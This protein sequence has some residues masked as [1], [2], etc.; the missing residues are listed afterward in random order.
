METEGRLSWFPWIDYRE[1]KT[2]RSRVL[3]PISQIRKK[4]AY[5]QAWRSDSQVA[6]L[7]STSQYAIRTIC[8]KIDLS[9][10]FHAIEYGAGTGE[11]AR[12]LL[13]RM[14]PDS[15]L[16]LIEKNPH[17]FEYLK[18]IT[19]PRVTAYLDS[20]ENL[21]EI[22]R[23]M[24]IKEIDYVISGIPFS[25]FSLETKREIL[26]NSHQ[27]LK[28]GSKFVAYQSLNHIQKHLELYFRRVTVQFEWRNIPP[29][30]IYEAT[31]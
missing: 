28:P 18:E 24:E 20:A 4:F 6:N 3:P 30:L 25:R 2:R 5:L 19:D 22:L 10:P 9:R 11:F 27:A 17:L 1:S 12:Y 16:I 13:K 29:L 26:R 8:D 15:S 21:P 31:K 14:R 23:T 7:F